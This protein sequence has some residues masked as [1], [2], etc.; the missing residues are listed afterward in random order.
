ML[1]G[2]WIV[3][4]HVWFLSVSAWHHKLLMLVGLLFTLPVFTALSAW[5][6]PEENIAGLKN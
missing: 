5:I 1:H 2:I 6:M 4:E 3:L